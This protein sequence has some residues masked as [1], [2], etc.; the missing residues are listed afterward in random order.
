MSFHKSFGSSFSDI[1]VILQTCANRPFA[2]QKEKAKPSSL[3]LGSDG[4]MVLHVFFCLC[5]ERFTC[6]NPSLLSK[7][8][9]NQQSSLPERSSVNDLPSMN[10]LDLSKHWQGCRSK[11]TWFTLGPGKAMIVCTESCSILK[12]TESC[13]LRFGLKA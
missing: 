7:L 9:E 4:E 11:S 1:K 2:L 13:W 8:Q 3:L 6:K 10:Q 12:I 5:G